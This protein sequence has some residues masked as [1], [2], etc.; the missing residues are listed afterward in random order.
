MTFKDVRESL[1][2]ELNQG[3]INS[4]SV[5]WEV[6]ES[7]EFFDRVNTAINRDIKPAKKY[8]KLCFPNLDKQS[9]DEFSDSVYAYFIVDGLTD[10]T[11]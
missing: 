5:D 11:S 3:A 9:D 6:I 2:N 1:H 8:A 10:K 4:G 7:Q